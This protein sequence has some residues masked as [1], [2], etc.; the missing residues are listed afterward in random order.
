MA[1]ILV[2]AFEI[3]LPSTITYPFKDVSSSSGFRHYIQALYNARVTTGTSTTTFSPNEPVKRAEMASFVVRAESYD[4]APDVENGFAQQVVEYTNKE[5]A[6][7]GLQPLEIYQPIMN[8][9]QIKSDDMSK[10]NYFSHNSPTY[11]TPFELMTSLGISYRAAGEN[12][13]KGQRTAQEVVEAW[14]NS[15]GHRANILNSNFTHIGVG[16]AQN[17]NY[18]TQQFIRP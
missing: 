6:K 17:G 15:E 12:I 10:N 16:Y 4:Q 7:Y 14:M 18:W 1:I 13:A 3:R 2:N 8:S 5:R 9:A 11:G